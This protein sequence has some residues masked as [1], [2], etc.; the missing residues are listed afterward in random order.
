MQSKSMAL[1]TLALMASIVTFGFQSSMATAAPSG[2]RI[3][4]SDTAKIEKIVLSTI[5]NHPEIILKSLQQAMDNEQKKQLE[6]AEAAIKQNQTALFNDT[7]IPAAGNPQGDVRIV[8]FFDYNC[9]YCRKSSAEL[10]DLLKSDP[11]VRVFFRDLPIFGAP[12]TTLTKI[13]LAANNQ[14]KYLELHEAF[15]QTD[16]ALDETNA[17]KIAKNLG[18]DITKLQKDMN[19]P[20]IQKII[21]SNKKL[22]KT[23]NINATPAFIVEEKFVPGYISKD[24]FKK[25]L[26]EIR[27]PLQANIEKPSSQ[28]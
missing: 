27:T 24:A 20:E 15:M 21:A 17:L 12:S 26:L 23:L 8:T 18:L 10:Y 22:A 13:A 5:E 1:S 4:A 16:E 14:G 9:G 6:L 25:L 11:N 19:S 2:Q 3:S 28:S 7:N